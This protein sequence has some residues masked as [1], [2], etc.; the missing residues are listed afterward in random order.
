MKSLRKIFFM[1][2]VTA[3]ISSFSAVGASACDCEHE[4]KSHAEES[5]VSLDSESSEEDVC[6]DCEACCVSHQHFSKQYSGSQISSVKLSSSVK[7]L[8]EENIF[9]SNFIEVLKSPPK[10]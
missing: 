9:K 7:F 4:S 10:A 6:I 2:L 5:L 3:F 1:F 8:S